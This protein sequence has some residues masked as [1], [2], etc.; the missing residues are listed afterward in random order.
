MKETKADFIAAIELRPPSR[1]PAFRHWYTR[2]LVAKY[3]EPLAALMREHEDGFAFA[4]FEEREAYFVGGLDEWGCRWRYSP[5]GVGAQVLENPLTD[6]AQLGEYLE[7]HMPRMDAD[8]RLAIAGRAVQA[9]PGKFVAGRLWRVFAERMQIL[10]GMER[11]LVDLYEHPREINVLA[12]TLA[13]FVIGMIRLFK[14]AG[15]DGVFLGDDWGTQSGLLIS[16]ALWRELFKPWYERMCRAAHDEGLYV[17]FHSCGNIFP[18]I[19]DLIEVGVD[20]LNP[21]QPNAMDLGRVAAAYRGRL[22]FFGGIDTQLTLATGTPAAVAAEVAWLKEI[23]AAGNGGYIASPSTTV[24]PET[25][26][27]NIEAMCAALA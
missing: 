8:R 1:I 20:V 17:L 12:E 27:A 21:I 6:W 9:N 19:G 18:L 10:R 4:D 22:C 13:E 25:P 2:E 3:G 26:F 24:M 11:F 23:F 16:P 15:V 5:D 14:R 7:E